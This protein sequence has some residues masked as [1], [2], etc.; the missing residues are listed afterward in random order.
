MFC[1]KPSLNKPSFKTTKVFD[2]S[3]QCRNCENPLSTIKCQ[4]V[5]HVYHNDRPEVVFLQDKEARTFMWLQENEVL[6]QENCARHYLVWLT[7][8]AEH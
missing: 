7:L 2:L 8:V 3:F 1:V 6:G 5:R 4:G